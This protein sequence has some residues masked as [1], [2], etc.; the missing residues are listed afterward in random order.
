MDDGILRRVSSL[1]KSP[2]ARAGVSCRCKTASRTD[3]RCSDGFVWD[4]ISYQDQQRIS[5]YN[6]SINKAADDD[7]TKPLKEKPDAGW[8]IEM[9]GWVKHNDDVELCRKSASWGDAPCTA[10][11]KRNHSGGP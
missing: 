9:V 5:V 1:D 4:L 10:P 8:G 7:V 11:P 2:A 3:T 6:Y